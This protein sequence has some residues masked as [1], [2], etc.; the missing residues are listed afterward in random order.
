MLTRKGARDVVDTELA[1][2]LKHTLPRGRLPT[3]CDVIERVL[4]ETNWRT[5]E[6]ARDVAEEV[7]DIWM[8][9]TVYPLTKKAVTDKIMASVQE[10]S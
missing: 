6:T 5:R 8:H 9:C 3:K 2:S 1:F 7:I 4:N 10:L